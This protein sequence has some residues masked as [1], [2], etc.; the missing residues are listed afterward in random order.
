MKRHFY[1]I[2]FLTF[3]ICTSCASDKKA[4]DETPYF[5]GEIKLSESR[6]M[7]GSLFKVHTTY[8]ISENYIKR[9]QKLGGLQSALNIYSGL[10]IDLEKDS[11]TLYHANGLNSEKVKHTLSVKDYKAK[12]KSHYFPRSIPSSLDNTFRLLNDYSLEKHVKD[13]TTIK[14]FKSDYS[15][16]KDS[17]SLFKQEVFDTKDIK[18]K[19]ELLEMVF[20]NIPEG[21]NFP[22]KSQFRTTITDISNDS[23]IAG[24]QSKAID[25]FLRDV[26]QKEDAPNTKKRTRLDKVA[27][28][29]WVKL[30]LKILKKGVDLNIEINSEIVEIFDKPMMPNA[31]SLPSGDFT[32]IIDFDEFIDISSP[33]GEGFD[34]DD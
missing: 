16:L 10:I 3:A 26:F 7:Y 4:E 11:V 2:Y 34:F 29:K 32:E 12:I 17:L 8:L 22:L 30:G 25:K 28:N 1:Y 23:I 31:F 27:K 15:L 20:L 5:E 18:I 19:R 33:S 13:S 9:E 21:I 24:E 14:N 6:G